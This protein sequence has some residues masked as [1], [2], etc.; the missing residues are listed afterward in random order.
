V[1]LGVE[2][3]RLGGEGEVAKVEGES[4]RGNSNSEC[5]TTMVDEGGAR[6]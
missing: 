3:E 2:R 5:A 1:R 4:T 6:S